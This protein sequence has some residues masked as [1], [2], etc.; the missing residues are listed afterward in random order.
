MTTLTDTETTF[1][2][3]ARD[4]FAFL[5]TGYGC[6][7]T[8]EPEATGVLVRF[9]NRWLAIDVQLEAPHILVSLAR[10]VEG[11]M[12]RRFDASGNEVLTHVPLSDLIRLHDPGWQRPRDLG[13]TPTADDI[14][15]VVTEYSAGLK[16]YGDGLLRGDPSLWVRLE[17]D[18]REGLVGTLIREWTQ[19]VDRVRVG[20][21]GDIGEYTLGIQSRGQ[22]EQL[23]RET[24]SAA[25]GRAIVESLDRSFVESTEAMEARG[26][27]RSKTYSVVPD[28]HATRWWRR[29][30]RLIG[31]LRDYFKGH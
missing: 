12:P 21:T 24:A 13:Q 22:L 27:G 4:A 18:M 26:M 15:R 1:V 8:V 25:S 20:F 5:R 28:A 2:S 11:E 3:A 17:R 7:S 19:F 9:A 16:R 30:K 31:P 14:R 29:P 6:E 10:L 23:L